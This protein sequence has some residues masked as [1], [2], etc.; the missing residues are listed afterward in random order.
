MNSILQNTD[1]RA[2][3]PCAD[4]AGDGAGAVA[5]AP[6]PNGSSRGGPSRVERIYETLREDIFELRLRP[7]D[8]VS[9]GAVAERFAVSRTPAREAMQRLQSDGLMRSY[10]R[11][12][13]EV[14]P[15]DFSR[16]DDLYE[17]RELIETY[18]VR[19]V[20]ELY[21]Q[22]VL[23]VM[24]ALETL[25]AS[26]TS[27]NGPL[28]AHRS[29]GQNSQSSQSGQV[30]A[31][32]DE[33]FHFAIVDVVGNAELSAALRRVTDRLRV[34]RRL[35]F[36]DGDGDCIGKMYGEHTA[37]LDAIRE[38]RCEDAVALAAQHVRHS[39][40]E[41]CKLAA[42][43]LARARHALARESVGSITRG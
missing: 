17:M 9:E 7:G 33:A 39:Q 1:I 15:I 23:S 40:A 24:Q 18:A 26:W 38:A 19:R 13:W 29:N 10:V 22:G 25:A 27:W 12:G 14:A 8:R 42:Q 6:P 43:R 30:V 5:Y 35:G 2:E 4:C 3:R 20:C 28:A 31:A 32:L 11:G 37:L 21:G 41:I 36:V 34:V 16:F